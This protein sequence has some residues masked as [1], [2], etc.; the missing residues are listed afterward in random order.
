MVYAHIDDEVRDLRIK[1][2][3]MHRQQLE[4]SSALLDYIR[5]DM[6]APW[7]ASATRLE[8]ILLEILK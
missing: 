7:M 1:L 3:N 5:A 8:G 4:L 2:G 6:A